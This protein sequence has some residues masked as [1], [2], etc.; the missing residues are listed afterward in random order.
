[1]G[2]WGTSLTYI[3]GDWRE[4]QVCNGETEISARSFARTATVQK[5]NDSELAG[6]ASA[7]GARKSPVIELGAYRTNPD[8]IPQ[9]PVVLHT[10]LKTCNFKFYFLQQ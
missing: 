4:K 6:G 10:N 9:N 1:M 7:G 8:Y 2:T 3:R 5:K